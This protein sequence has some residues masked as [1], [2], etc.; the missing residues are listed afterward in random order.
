M[1]PESGMPQRRPAATS[2]VPAAPPAR[3]PGPPPGR[4]RPRG[5]AGPRSR[6]S[7]R[8]RRPAPPGRLG[9]QQRL[10]ADAVE[11]PRLHQLGLDEG[12]GHP[13][14]GLARE[15]HLA[16]RHR[17]HGAGND[18]RRAR[19]ELDREQ[20]EAPEVVDVGGL[21]APTPPARRGLVEAGRHQEP[22]L[23]RQVPDEELE[24]VRLGLHAG[25]LVG[26][27]HGQLVQVGDQRRRGRHPSA[28]PAAAM[29][30]RP[31]PVAQL[32]LDRADP[33][34]DH[35]GGEAEAHRAERRLLHAVVGGQADHDHRPTSWARRRSS[36]PVGDDS[37]EVGCAIEARI[38]VLAAGALAHRLA[39]DREAGQ[40]PPG[41]GHA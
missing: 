34:G 6:R 8:S 14:Q 29:V 28:T 19:Q 13:H 11:Q 36:R 39:G 1:V 7:A 5:P 30:H 21:E 9:G 17:P 41:P 22:P 12:A 20:P 38:A 37:P 4:R 23:G 25:R 32:D 35:G 31:A 40:R 15:D 10:A 24:Q 33:V 2:E 16:L 26:G 3:R 18:S 27:G